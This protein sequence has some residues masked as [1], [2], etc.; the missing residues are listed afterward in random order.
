MSLINQALRKAQHQ[1][2]P[3][4][5]N[6]S[7]ATPATPQPQFQHNQNTKKSGL[8]VGLIIGIAV[9]I[10]L[11]SGL[12]VVLLNKEPDP[13]A[14][15]QEN[16]THTAE[17]ATTPQVTQPTESVTQPRIATPKAQP[18]ALPAD[19]SKLQEEL[20]R[21]REAAEAQI[22]ADTAAAAKAKADALA[23]EQAAEAKLKADQ[24]AAEAEASKAAELAAT[25]ANEEIIQWLSTATI[26]GTRIS[27][28]GNKVILNNKGYDEGDTVNLRLG[29][30]LLI[31][32]EN[33][34]LFVD[35]NGKRYM[36]QL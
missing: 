19:N 29:I 21:A 34:L 20:R 13:A 26:S 33:R 14:S 8:L 10:G 3:N 35:A 4:A 1:R 36:K 2:S 5:S 16:T 22:A 12:T 28:K 6:T 15:I 32:Q 11:V 24:E 30:K 27:S 9:L 23:A 18:L 7:A 25:T 17:P 31:I